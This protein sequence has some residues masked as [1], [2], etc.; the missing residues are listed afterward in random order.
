MKFIS[1]N[2]GLRVLFYSL[3]LASFPCS[4][5]ARAH[6]SPLCE[7]YFQQSITGTVSDASGSLPGVIIMVKGTTR[8]T[9]SDAEGRFSIAADNNEV[10]VFSFTGFKAVEAAIGEQT[11]F[12]IILQEDATQLE[13]LEINAGYYSV[14]QKESTGNISRITSK[15]I[16]TQPVTNVLATMQGRMP[17]VSITQST[18]TPGGG[19][20]IAIRG[21][22]SLR[23]DANA[24]LYIIDGVPYSS[25]SIGSSYTSATLFPAT[26]NP[27]N[28]ISLDAI[29]SIEVLKDADATAIYG[30]RGANGVVL[31][32]T[33]KG[34]IGKTQVSV[35]ASTGVGNITRFM[36]LMNTQQYLAMRAKAFENDGITQYPEYAYDINGAWDRN[37]YTDWQKELTGGTSEITAFQ[38]SVSG[39]TGQTQFLFGTNYHTQTSVVPGNFIYK[40]G[41][42]N[43]SLNHASTDERFK[44]SLSG[45]YVVQD[46]DQ[47]AF[48]PTIDSRSLA[49][50]APAL[51]DT[52]G[53][54]NWEN[55]TWTNPLANLA[56]EFKSRTNDFIANSVLS[57]TLT[58]DLRIKSS[59]GYSTTNHDETRTAPSTV[60]NPAFNLGSEYSALFVNTV[61]RRSWIAEPQ[62][63]YKLDVSKAKFDV[64]VG[65]TFQKQVSNNLTQYGI[66]FT[67]NSL[68]YNLAAASSRT[69]PLSDEVTYKY[70]AFF[71]RINLKWDSKYI[72]NFTARRDGSSRFGPENQFAGFAA[73]GTAWIFSEETFLKNQNVVSFGKIRGS[74]G[75]TG[76]DQIGDYQFLDTY[77]SS[78][79][80]YQGVV[81]LMPSRLYNPDFGWEKTK[82]L[83]AA[84]ELGFLKDRIFLT[85]AYYRNRSS[86]QL[87]GLPVPATTGFTSLQANLNATVQNTGFEVSLDTKNIDTK[88]F[89]W[90]TNINLTLP[91]NKLVSF[92]GLESSVYKEQYRIGKPLAIR[93]VYNYKGINE[94]TGVYQFED[95]NGDGQITSPDDKQ[96][97]VDLSPEFYGGL[98]NQIR[99]KSW[100]LNFLFQFV[101][102]KNQG[103]TLGNGGMMNNQPVELVNSWQVPGDSSSHQVYTTGFNSEA[104]TAQSLYES[105]NANIVDASFIRLKNIAISYTLPDLSNGLKSS[106]LLQAQ[107]LLTITPYKGGDPEFGT[108]G[109]L[110]P[111]RV[112]SAG[113]QLT[114]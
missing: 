41:G 46:N 34:A 38:G 108:L 107:N 68:I 76:S 28:S 85:A 4:P 18:G 75:S 97:A 44:L 102:Q 110:P 11:I 87:V 57:Y 92:P 5:L 13:E 29:A 35:N 32:T 8:S 64:L 30:S 73:L 112:I 3:T 77:T 101:K 86:N 27:L 90:S 65:G 40:K 88:D 47:P 82:K 24:P 81:G 33:K 12:N 91:R 19:F 62:V 43:F 84:L 16:E 63:S 15:E 20:D 72:I 55:G 98:Q 9:I 45:S 25:E 36:N 54:L 80:M 93:M 50:N 69:I 48:D 61:S 78:G 100:T 26:S 14:K 104:V 105:S 2:N 10:L 103:F 1:A 71:G 89:S 49:P 83:E 58:D 95:V 37:R 96:T 94:Q 6:A 66:G 111:L 17:G 23:G 74:Y 39:G 22:N 52:Q 106:I 51:Y 21:R 60:Y 42:G 67:S 56:A 109:F 59:F 99:Y 31:I 79:V 7:A 70:Q 53:N 114:F 113:I